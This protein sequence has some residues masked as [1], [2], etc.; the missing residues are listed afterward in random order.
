MIVKKNLM[1]SKQ[2]LEKPLLINVQ[3]AI[4][5]K[6]ILIPKKIEFKKWIRQSLQMINYLA[7]KNC[8]VTEITIRIVGEAESAALNNKY[9]HK[10]YATNILSFPSDI[11]IELKNK[12]LGDLVICAPVVERE[13]MEQRKDIIAHWAHLTI[14]GVL[15]LLNYD[16]N[17][18][19]AASVMEALEIKILKKLDFENPY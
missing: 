7:P 12:I 16:H 10:N 8:A 19:E 13:A 14:H 2:K 3:K 1:E 5:S 6:D 15:H 17:T 4:N 18:T 11:P 9:R